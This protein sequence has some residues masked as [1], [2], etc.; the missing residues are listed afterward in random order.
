MAGILS[1][2]ST[3][4]AVFLPVWLSQCRWSLR[5]HT[6]LSASLLSLPM[7]GT[8]PP[9]HQWEVSSDSPWSYSYVIQTMVAL[10]KVPKKSGMFLWKPMHS[11]FIVLNTEKDPTVFEMFWI[12]YIIYLSFS[13]QLIKIYHIQLW[14]FVLTKGLCFVASFALNSQPPLC[15][16][17]TAAIPGTSHHI[18]LQSYFTS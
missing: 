13:A 17:L 8:M 4:R 7:W 6:L 16:L 12:C 2:P 18:W 1:G 5:P 11:V 10:M 3:V 15:A 14:P 9:F